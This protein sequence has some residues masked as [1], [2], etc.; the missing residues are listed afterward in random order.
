MAKAY[1]TFCDPMGC[2][3][4]V[5]L[6]VGFPRQEYWGRLSFPS[7]GDLHFPGIEPASYALQ[8]DSFTAEPLRTPT[9]DSYRM[10]K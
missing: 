10:S 3:R 9:D 5:S 7:P 2:T 6:S 1:P 4:Q 8:A